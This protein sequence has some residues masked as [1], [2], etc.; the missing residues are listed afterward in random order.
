MRRYCFII[1]FLV[2]LLA[3]LLVHWLYGAAS[4]RETRG[5]ASGAARLV[6]I[7]PHDQDIRDEFRRAFADWHQRTYGQR[8]DLE[9][10][11]PGG[12]TD[13][14]RQLQTIYGEIRKRHGGSLPDPEQ[15]DVGID[16][17]WG[18][19]D[20]FF[21]K[22]L[23]PL[24]I[25]QPLEGEGQLLAD[26][27]PQ[28]TLAGVK[29]YDQDKDASGNPLPPQWVGVC[30]S[31]FGIVYNPDLCRSLGVPPVATWSDLT[32]P[33]LAG[34]LS[35]ADPTH[36]GSAAMTYMMIIQRAMADAEGRFFGE[37]EN[38]GESAARLKRTPEYQ[39]ALDRGWSQGMRELLLI[40]AN[41][42]QFSDSATDPPNDV[43]SGEAAAGM[44]IDFYG[45]VTQETVG[46]GRER[47]VA[48][49]A[50]TA[51]T[52]D[53][54]A[55]L[56]GCHGR[57][58]TLA[59]HFVEFLLSPQG[60]RLW[61]LNPGQEGGPRSRA[62]RR[63]PI[64]Q[65]VYLDRRG[66]ADDTDYFANAGGF[67]ERGEWMAT[68]GDLRPIWAA[69]WIDDRDDLRDAYVR[70]LAVPDPQRRAALIGELSDLPVTRADVTGLMAQRRR[71]ESDPGQDA[72][73]WKA[74]ERLKWSALFGNHYRQVAADAEQAGG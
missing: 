18:G 42:G 14:K 49:T 5:W 72:D 26:A 68:L 73:M 41:A 12:T 50:A 57:Q 55:I 56:Y 54:V 10:L 43:A 34:A 11:S 46:A 58:L 13:I 38:W 44:A 51:I 69:A 3:P 52:P 23:K 8:V 16:L 32:N 28:P 4:W 66:W 48:P 65:S 61:I 63:S 45:R 67:N 37:P 59:R 53:P 47:F 30:L 35:L 24:G 15:T 40:A 29:L 25:L 19:G 31:S 36:S 22:E 17:A 9:F 2:L 6:I 64:R 20:Y 74:R 60:Q 39:Q 27:F 7:T 1:A 71:V 70:V 21:D 62:L 33:R